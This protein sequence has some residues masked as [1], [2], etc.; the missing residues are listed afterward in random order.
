MFS[1]FMVLWIIFSFILIFF[2]N[3]P[4]MWYF[5]LLRCQ[6]ML[7]SHK[8]WGRIFFSFYNYFSSLSFC[9]CLFNYFLFSICFI[10]C[11][12]NWLVHI[13]RSGFSLCSEAAFFML[14]KLILHSK[15]SNSYTCK[16]II[17][18]FFALLVR[19]ELF[20]LKLAPPAQKHKLFFKD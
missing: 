9:C 8:F 6:A 3:M 1:D 17:S 19:T 11:Y 13:N 10:F 18:T 16:Q 14:S 4:H 12:P 5:G 7:I 15:L 2:C 20:V